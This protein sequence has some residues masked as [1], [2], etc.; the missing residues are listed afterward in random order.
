MDDLASVN[1][2]GRL[3]VLAFKGLQKLA[4]H[5][6]QQNGLAGLW[7][8]VAPHVNKVIVENIGRVDIPTEA[9]VLLMILQANY[10]PNNGEQL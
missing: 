2:N 5:I 9:R 10:K 8:A 6:E 7:D 3:D 1:P 4:K